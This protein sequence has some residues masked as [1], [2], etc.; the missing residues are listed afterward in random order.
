[1]PYLL[2]LPFFSDEAVYLVR[3]DVFPAM[4][5]DTLRGGK[6]LQEVALAG[7]LL[8]PGDGLWLARLFSILC[9]L[10]TIL[11]LQ[12]VARTLEQPAAGVVAGLF[13]IG[14]PNVV[15]HD[16]LGV[17]EGMLTLAGMFVLLSSVVL[18]RHPHPT[19]RLAV[20]LGLLLG[21]SALVK[22]SGLF[23]FAIPVFAVLFRAPAAERWQWLALLRTSL[24]VALLCIAA[25]APFNYGGT[26]NDKANVTDLNNRLSSIGE[27]I[28]E[29]ASWTISYVPGTLLLLPILLLAFRP[30]ARLTIWPAIGMLLASTFTISGAYIV[31]GQVIYPRYFMAVWPLVLL[32][33]ALAA[34]ALWKTNGPGRLPARGLLVAIL[35]ATAAWDGYFLIQLFREPL[36]APLVAVD[37][38]QHL[39]GWTASADIPELV[40]TLRAEAAQHGDILIIHPRI[41]DS[42]PLDRLAHLAPRFYLNDNS[43]VQFADL[44]LYAE[45]AAQQIQR[46]AA[47]QPTYIVLDRQLYAGA[48]FDRR[49]PQ[50]VLVQ[51]YMNPDGEMFFAIY[52]FRL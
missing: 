34:V 11:M 43:S 46:L 37:R 17:P 39:E 44:D 42:P 24:I 45:D 16:R 10:G 27:N 28:V 6:L 14:A 38:H 13:Y 25:L 1:V 22:I 26:T 36:N 21:V 7:F 29:L 4:L 2:R 8:L 23:F 20:W 9:G 47:A 31:L 48:A 50:A 18:A 12:L 52:R 32:A 51:S 35:V 33:A 41:G 30:Q 3:A 15:L 19:R 5:F 49:F 40:D